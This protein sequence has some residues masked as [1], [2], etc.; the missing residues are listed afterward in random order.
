MAQWAW[1]RLEH[2]PGR[3][4]GPNHVGQFLLAP[5][6][7][8]TREGTLH[9]MNSY[10]YIGHFSKFIPSGART[11]CGVPQPRATA[12][13][14]FQNTDGT[15]AVVVMNKQSTAV[16]LGCMSGNRRSRQSAVPIQS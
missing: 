16:N 10:Y 12:F 15:I 11:H 8:K 6:H 14:S 3:K 5:V 4:G 7:A 9:Y 1:N 13:H 2:P